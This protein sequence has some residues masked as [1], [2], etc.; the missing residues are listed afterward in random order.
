MLGKTVRNSV[1]IAGMLALGAGCHDLNVVNL[2]QPD[3]DRALAEPGDLEAL[4]GGTF[5][6][7]FNAVHSTGHT[8]NLFPVYA[9]EM[10]GVS[11]TGAGWLQGVE[12]RPILDNYAG[13]SVNSSPIGPRL[14][15]ADL[16]RIASSVHDGLSTLTEQGIQIREGTQD[17]T[18]RTRAF[19]KFMQGLAWGY[20]AMLYDQS[21]IVDETTPFVSDPVRQ[22]VESLTPAAQVRSLA[23][24]SL[25]ESVA[26]AEQFNV[27]FP[28]GTATR[29]FF[30]TPETISTA[31]FVSLTNT[32]AARILVL[33]AR[34]PQE[35]E[36]VDWARV[37]QYTAHGLT[38]DFEV[39]LS[40]DLRNSL[41]YARMETNSAG[42]VN[43]YRWDNR[44]IG[45]ADVSGAY[46]AWIA[47]PI[48]DRDRFDIVTPDRR[49]T[50]ANPRSDGAYTRY[51][52]HDNGFPAARGVY[53]RSA[54]QWARHHH[55]GFQP[56]TGTAPLVT[57]DE[58]NLLRA[59]ALLR[60]GD[61]DGAATLINITRTR[62]HTLPNG[63]T[64]PGLPPV[65]ATG[66]PQ[67]AECAPRTDAGECGD[68][69]TA[70]RY[71]RMIELAGL[72]AVRGYLDSRGFGMLPDGS[73]LQLPMPGDQLEL[74]GLP[75][76][77][78]GGVGTEWG[79]VY[80]PTTIPR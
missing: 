77:S 44:L 49:I 17:V 12:P 72:D 33:S 41:L 9:T 8:V 30:G 80:A 52:S 59:E 7:F 3:R 35:R 78:F 58:N 70:L 34:T 5:G 36:D 29:L 14:L 19:G 24:A 6:V 67:H 13:L 62:E 65:T 32:L 53:R 42:C 26:I 57:V 47:S 63:S 64:H 48:E 37:L 51:F 10:T 11:T 50:G 61:R 20:M 69:L 60:T 22:G 74:M 39:I 75:I 15:L 38:R 45:M 2:D 54:Y 66:V 31:D 73:W 68:L 43:C 27:A 56:N 23:L 71:E 21:I 79:A 46:Q 1:A 55:R 76:Y 18:H 40:P 25:A 16:H 28:S 4:I